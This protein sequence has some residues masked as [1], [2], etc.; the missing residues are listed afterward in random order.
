MKFKSFVH[1]D[2]INKICINMRPLFCKSIYELLPV[3]LQKPVVMDNR[4]THNKSYCY[5]SSSIQAFHGMPESMSWA[6]HAPSVTREKP[7]CLVR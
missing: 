1:I 2:H 4:Y 6:S 3:Y 7:A 5:N